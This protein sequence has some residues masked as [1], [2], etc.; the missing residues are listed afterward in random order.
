MDVLGCDCGPTETWQIII[1]ESFHAVP[2]GPEMPDDAHALYEKPDLFALKDGK[3]WKAGEPYG[4]FFMIK[5]DE[6][7]PATD[8]GWTYATTSMDGTK[9]TS[10]GRVASCMECHADAPHDRLFGLQKP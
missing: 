9:V 6:S 5:G 2:Y 4:L 3:R 7:D 1:K 8:G 10:F